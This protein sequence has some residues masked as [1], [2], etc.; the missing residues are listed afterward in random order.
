MQ[1]VV[2]HDKLRL[3]G[4]GGGRRGGK[5]RGKGWIQ[6]VVTHHHTTFTTFHSRRTTKARLKYIS[7]ESSFHKLIKITTFKYILQRKLSSCLMPSYLWS[8]VLQ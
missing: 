5:G 1:N 8:V 7:L 6:V 4:G 3:G 2:F